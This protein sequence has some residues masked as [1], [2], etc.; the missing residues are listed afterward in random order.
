MQSTISKL[1][2]L[3]LILSVNT[4]CQN[5]WITVDE[6]DEFGVRSKGAVNKNENGDL[7]IITND[8]LGL[9]CNEFSYKLKS[10]SRY[11]IDI[12]IKSNNKWTNFRFL[13]EPYSSDIYLIIFTQLTQTLKSNIEFNQA[14][15]N[16]ER[17]SFRVKENQQDLF[18]D[19]DIT[20]RFETSGI[21]KIIRENLDVLFSGEVSVTDTILTEDSIINDTTKN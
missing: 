17:V 7:F 20:I 2:I 4:S 6:T 15:S 3:A 8:A 11:Y 14:L 12:A 5:N 9:Q 10:G 1:V 18:D 16:S 21:D 19:P 13:S